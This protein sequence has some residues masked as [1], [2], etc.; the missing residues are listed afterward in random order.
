M[1][2]FV[3]LTPVYMEYTGPRDL[4]NFVVVSWDVEIDRTD[5]PV[6]I[7]AE[8]VLRRKLTQLLVGVYFP[9]LCIMVIAQV[10]NCCQLNNS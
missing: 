5:S 1:K 7:R 6:H 3:Q 9:S 8:V 4:Q 10:K 2:K